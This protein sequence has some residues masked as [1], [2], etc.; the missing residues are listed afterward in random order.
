MLSSCSKVTPKDYLN[1]E[2]KLDIRQYLSGD[3]KAWGILQDRKGKVTR[4]FVVEMTGVWDGDNGTLTEHFEFDDGQ[5]DK[6]IWK[7]NFSDDNNFT[8]TAGDVVGNAI[9]SQYGSAMQ[10]DYI[11]DLEVDEGKRYKV[12][13]DDWMYLI[14]EKTLVNKSKIKKFGITFATLTIFFQK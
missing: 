9:G 5:K 14:D 8:A 10:M 6:R 4:K 12:K 13:L 2:P 11:L 1:T 7:I 3:I